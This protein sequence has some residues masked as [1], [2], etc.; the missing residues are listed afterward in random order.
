MQN[1]TFKIKTQLIGTN[2]EAGSISIIMAC[3]MLRTISY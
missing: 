1:E 2:Y 3:A